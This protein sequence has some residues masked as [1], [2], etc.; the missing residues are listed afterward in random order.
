MTA[1]DEDLGRA[2]QQGFDPLLPAGGLRRLVRILDN[3]KWVIGEQQDAL[4]AEAHD[5]FGFLPLPGRVAGV[6]GAEAGEGLDAIVV[7]RED[8]PFDDLGAE[9]ELSRGRRAEQEAGEGGVAEGRAVGGGAEDDSGVEGFGQGGEVLQGAVEQ[10]L[11]VEGGEAV[12]FRGQGQ[13]AAEDGRGQRIGLGPGEQRRE[14]GEFVFAGGERSQREALRAI[15]G[16]ERRQAGLVQQPE[17]LGGFRSKG[18][19]PVGEGSAR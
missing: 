18:A 17:E 2:R 9:P 8:E 1:M 10:R 11:A 3:V 15:E 12:E 7:V 14:D 5:A 4:G 13:D 16:G 6:G 19:A